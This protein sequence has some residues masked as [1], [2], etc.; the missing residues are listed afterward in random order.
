MAACDEQLATDNTENS[1]ETFLG[2]EEITQIIRQELQSQHFSG[3][4]KEVNE[5]CYYCR[6]N[7]PILR[8]CRK[9][10]YTIWAAPNM[11]GNVFSSNKFLLSMTETF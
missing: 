4:R 11:S 1:S 5:T 2:R 8:I 9:R 7:G 3:Q 10:Q 6:E